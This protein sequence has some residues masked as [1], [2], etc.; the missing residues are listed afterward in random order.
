V[1]PRAGLDVCE[2]SR[3]HRDLFFF[4]VTNYL[5]LY[6]TFLSLLPLSY[7]SGMHPISKTFV[8]YQ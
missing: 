1:D 6:L 7:D 2:K 8:V 5:T 3:P 4:I